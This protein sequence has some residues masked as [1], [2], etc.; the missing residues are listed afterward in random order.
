MTSST[1]SFKLKAHAKF[2]EKVKRD[3]FVETKTKFKV[4]ASEDTPEAL[5]EATSSFSDL[6]ALVNHLLGL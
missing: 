6:K 4:K 1:E 3:G 2:H 5:E